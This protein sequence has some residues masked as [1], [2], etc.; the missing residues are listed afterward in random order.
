MPSC[1]GLHP[2]GEVL[3]LNAGRADAARAGITDDWDDPLSDHAESPMLLVR[4]LNVI[5]G[6]L[7]PIMTRKCV[8]PIDKRCRPK[9]PQRLRG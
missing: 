9:S 5:R 7:D 8:N 6:V 2:H 1:A 4:Q 3:T